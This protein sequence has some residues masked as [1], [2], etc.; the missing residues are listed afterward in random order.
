MFFNLVLPSSSSS[1]PAQS[2]TGSIRHSFLFHSSSPP[3][4]KSPNVGKSPKRL[5]LPC[6]LTHPS[7]P[8]LRLPSPRHLS[9]SPLRRP[10]SPHGR[11]P[12]P[13]PSSTSPHHLSP[14]RLMEPVPN[15]LLAL[16]QR[17]RAYLYNQN[18]HIVVNNTTSCSPSSSSS[19]ILSTCMAS[20]LSVRHQGKTVSDPSP[21]PPSTSQE[22]LAYMEK[23]NKLAFYIEPLRKSVKEYEKKSDEGEVSVIILFGLWVCGFLCVC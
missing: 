20:S 14:C 13:R 16:R 6:H 1:S 4:A 11:P 18:P 7:S 8:R 5:P 10:P 23:L 15:E 17:F 2:P 3:T 9:A 19:T 22:E 21:G 12:S